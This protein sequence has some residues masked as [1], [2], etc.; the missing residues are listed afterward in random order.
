MMV[1]ELGRRGTIQYGQVCATPMAHPIPFKGKAS[2]LIIP[3]EILR[4]K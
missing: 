2:H 1:A 3:A 4:E